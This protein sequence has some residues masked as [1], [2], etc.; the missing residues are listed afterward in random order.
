MIYEYDRS[1]S[2]AISEFAPNNS[3]YVDGKKLI[4]DQVDIATSKPV[5]WRLCP[6]CSHS[7]EDIAGVH[8]ASC[9]KCHTPA[10]ADGGQ[11]R[12][13]LKVQMV[14]SN[15]DYSKSQISDESEDRVNT[16]FCKQLLVDVDEEKDI[17]SAFEMHNNDFPFGYEFVRKAILR[18]INF[19]ER[20]LVGEKL[21]VS[22][23]DDIRKGFKI[24]KFCGKSNLL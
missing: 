5:K 7:E 10:W 3:F 1:A 16:F 15:M 4:I 17:T 22:G 20:D 9:P 11:A 24:C 23:I 18:E 19:G 6:N 21:M 2:A 13:M 8:T 14:Y 12:S